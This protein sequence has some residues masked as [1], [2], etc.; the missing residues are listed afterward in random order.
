MTLVWQR[1]G[2]AIGVVLL[3]LAGCGGLGPPGGFGFGGPTV[4]IT[5]GGVRVGPATPDSGSGAQLVNT[6]DSRSN[7]R[8]GSR[9][10]LQG[11]VA[12]LGAACAMTVQRIGG[13][14]APLTG[15]SLG[16]YQ[17]ADDSTGQ[18]ADEAVD[19]VSGP[20]VTTRSG[21]FGCAGS[22]CDGFALS[23]S[24][25]DSTLAEGYM[26]G[27]LHDGSGTPVAVVCSFYLLMTQY[28]P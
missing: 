17:V 18:T 10:T 22:E 6:Y 9:L 7:A 14:S 2:R 16:S 20:T 13:A 23:L 8:V 27:T 24:I 15:I 19:L 25:L 21:S 3:A 4:E 12:S 26:S 11:S 5:V 28:V 1:R